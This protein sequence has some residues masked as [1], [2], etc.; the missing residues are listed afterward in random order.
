MPHTKGDAPDPI[1]IHVGIRIRTRRREL[2]LSQEKLADAIG[3]TS[4]QTQKQER[5]A[6]RVSASA[7]YK[8]AKTLKVEPG[9]FF[10]GLGTS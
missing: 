3:V 4:Q 6:N 5:G 2:G 8:I 10:E 1:D 7:L 9:Y